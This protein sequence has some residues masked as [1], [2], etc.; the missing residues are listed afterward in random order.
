[1]PNATTNRVTPRASP[2]NDLKERAQ[3]QLALALQHMAH[4]L[5]MF[6]SN[7]RLTLCNERYREI[8]GFPPEALRPGVTFRSLLEHGAGLAANAGR[9]VDEVYADRMAVLRGDA[10]PVFRNDMADGRVI[11]VR[12]SPAPDGSWIAT[13]EDITDAVRAEEALAEKNRLL[14]IALHNMRQGLALY[15]PDERLI[16]WNEQFRR[17]YKLDEG[18]LRRGMTLQA[19]IGVVTDAGNQN[20]AE[21]PHLYDV[22]VAAIRSGQSSLIRQP[23]HDGRLIE[24]A[25]KPLPDGGWVATYDDVTERET[26]A[27]AAE[28]QNRLFQ[29]AL[30]HMGQGLCMFDEDMRILVLNQRYLDIYHLDPATIKPGVSLRDAMRQSAAAGNFPD[31]SWEARFEEHCAQLK[32][33]GSVRAKRYLADGRTISVCHEPS[34]GGGWIATYEDVT[35]QSEVERRILH[36]ARHDALTD[37]PNRTLLHDRVAEALA[38]NEAGGARI[39]ILCIDLDRFKAV[40]DT[41]GHRGGDQLLRQ[42]GERLRSIVGSS[43]TIARLGG[44]E[45]AV[46]WV[47]ATRT[48]IA[49]IAGRITGGLGQPYQLE[50]GLAIVGASVGIAVGHDDGG[51]PELLMERADLA[52]Y[53]AKTVCKGSF[54]FFEQGLAAEVQARNAMERDLRRALPE[55]QFELWYQPQLDAHTTELNGFEALLRWRHPERGLVPPGHFVGLA[56]ETGLIVPLGEWVIREACREAATWPHPARVAVNVSA[57]QF[58]GP[59]LEVT[60]VQALAASGLAPHRLEIEVTESVLLANNDDTL[61]TLHRLR[62]LGIRIALDDF[63]TGYSSLSYIRSF[64]FNKVKIDRSFVQN[65]S[66]QDNCVAIVESIAMLGARLGIEITAEGV[67]TQ[68][69][70]RMVQVAG[71]TEIQGFLFGRP[72]PAAEA[73]AHFPKK[74]IARR[75]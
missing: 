4:G 51:D 52:L 25:I 60:I 42:V 11:E 12:Y 66:G 15:G 47:A 6:D 41:F 30:S 27:H 23:L 7:Q 49:E 44:D 73:R 26:A 17:L 21:E 69:Q 31:R 74:R 56:E 50:S 54:T 8:Y 14:D 46:L 16:V 39:G 13:Y 5:C 20:R 64:P 68:A 58:N 32:A 10:P 35:E 59:S 55:G 18:Q 65:L 1:M 34:P 22:R 2:A 70:L 29:T 36:M 19:V 72:A 9:S 71:C 33:E 75:A 53:R 3:S 40:N 37:L 61:A 48:E 24:T 28:K 38:A 43:G 67:E 62:A 63:G 45:F 57:S